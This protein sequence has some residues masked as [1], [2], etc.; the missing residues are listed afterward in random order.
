VETLTNNDLVRI[1][2]FLRQLYLPCSLNDFPAHVLSALSKLSSAETFLYTSFNIR[3]PVVPRCYTFPMAEVGL[4]MEEISVDHHTLVTHPAVNNHFKTH[5]EQVHA[6]SDIVT[7]QDLH[8]IE[9]WYTD[10]FQRFGIKDELGFILKMPTGPG[11]NAFHY[12]Q[13]LVAV[14]LCRDRLNFTE[15]DRLLLRIIQPHLKQAYENVAVFSQ[16]Q[17]QLSQQHQVTEQSGTIVLSIDADFQWMTQRAGTLL[18][19]YFSPTK[20]HIALPELLQCWI[21]QRSE[22]I[23]VDTIP[24]PQKPL[25]IEKNGNRLTIHLSY[26]PKAEQIYL[27][28]EETQIEQLSPQSLEILGLT[29]REAEVLFWV[30]KDQTTRE[31]AAQLGMSDRTAKKHLEHIYG[32][33]GVQTRTGAVIYALEKIGVISLS[34]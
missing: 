29:K 13:D 6:I 3:N 15:S 24:T 12:G 28:L 26:E 2:E 19:Q 34:N 33:L 32:K 8:G 11:H 30:A 7:E 22:Q 25:R 16:L 1:L 27:L 9:P 31:V 10:Y 17:D 18:H 5:N 21:K 23:Q 14:A 4:A 20:A